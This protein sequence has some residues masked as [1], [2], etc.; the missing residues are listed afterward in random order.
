MTDLLT[1]RQAMFCVEYII[2]QNGTEAAIRAGYNVA[3][4]A[5]TAVGNL[6]KPKIALCIERLMKERAARSAITGDTILAALWKNHL[7]AEDAGQLQH[8]NRALELLG[9][10]NRLFID[11][12]EQTV[13]I[14]EEMS[15]AELDTAIKQAQ[16]EIDNHIH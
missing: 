1:P 10:A 11:R 7:T 14:Y 8:S 6:L 4:A 9:K 13:T 5:V 15:D 16:T 3:G 2:D 12:V